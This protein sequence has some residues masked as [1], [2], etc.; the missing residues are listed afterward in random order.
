MFSSKGEKPRFCVAHEL[1]GM[2]DS[3]L[4]ADG[5]SRTKAGAVRTSQVAAQQQRIY[6]S[7]TPAGLSGGGTFSGGGGGDGGGG[8]HG[9]IYGLSLI[10]I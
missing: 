7:T 8:G 9:D 3:R 6:G 10:H 2:S 5:R 4:S 1:D